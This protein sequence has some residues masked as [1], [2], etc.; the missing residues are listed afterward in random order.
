LEPGETVRKK[1]GQELAI[2]FY[3]IGNDP[4]HKSLAEIVQSQAGKIGVKLNLIGEESDSYYKRRHG[5]D[6]GLITCDT[7][8]PPYD[9]HAYMSSMLVPS[10]SDY[11][12]Q[13]GL[14]EKPKIDELINLAMV[15]T[16]EG[17]RANKY[18]Q[19]LTILHDKAVYL[20]LF[21]RSIF[22]VHKSDRLD[23]VKFGSTLTQ[24]PFEAVSIK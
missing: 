12:A 4:S 16:D 22:S 3:F 9:P 20:P 5:G 18:K 2:D 17:E 8:G 24:T 23:G 7:W 11:A 21:H 1:D 15:A 10:H 14:A 19:V 6:F 13:S